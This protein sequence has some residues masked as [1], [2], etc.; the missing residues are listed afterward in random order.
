MVHEDAQLVSRLDPGHVVEGR[1][2]VVAFILD[3]FAKRLYEATT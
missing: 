1:D 3:T 2:E